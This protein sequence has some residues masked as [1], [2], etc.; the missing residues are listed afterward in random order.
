MAESKKPI[1]VATKASKKAETQICE[2]DS[3]PSCDNFEEDELVKRFEAAYS[4]EEKE[5]LVSKKASTISV[6]EEPV[7]SKKRPEIKLVKK[8]PP[9]PKLLQMPIA[10]PTMNQ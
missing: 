1:V 4:D 9:T 5:Q 8:A 6:L 7:K 10:K 2:S 3:E